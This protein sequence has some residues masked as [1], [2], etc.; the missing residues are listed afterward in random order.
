MRP[1]TLWYTIRQGF[2]NI[3]R[4]KTYSLASVATIAACL[5]LFG[6]MYSVVLNFQHIV[7]VAEEGVCV[8]VFFDEDWIN[9]T[10]EDTVAAREQDI[11]ALICNKKE[12]VS[13]ARFVTADD[14]WQWYQ[15]TYLDEE[16]ASSFP[17]NPLVGLENCE[18]YLTD[19]SHQAELVSWLE[20]IPEVGTIRQDTTLADTLGGVNMAVAYVSAAII[21]ILFAVALFLISNTII[22]GISVRQEEISI[23][24]YIGA[25]DFFV[26]APFV[27]EGMLIGLIGSAIPM[28]ALWLMYDRVIEFIRVKFAGLSDLLQ[29]LDAPAVFNT[30]IPACLI[31]GVCIGFLGSFSAVR[32]HLKA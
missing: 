3:F 12:W 26:R 7:R 8:T 22:V 17:T 4:N 32:R 28:V 19:V 2:R 21:L 13:R 9:E 31:I 20:Q 29:F 11:Y 23:M 16:S 10:P 5:F 18:V 24:K 1:S 25:T 30:L 14:A 15:D 27:I 6:V